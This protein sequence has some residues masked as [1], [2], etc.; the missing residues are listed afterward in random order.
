[1]SRHIFLSYRRL[2]SEGYAG[3]LFDRLSAHFG[4]R[5]LFMDVVAIDAGVDFAQELEEAVQ[6]CDVLLALI[7]PQWLTV[8][9]AQGKPRLEDPGD[10]VRLEIATALARDIRVIPVL[11]QGTSMPGA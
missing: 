3:R 2:D 10:Y 11:L 5:N 1:M 7:G 4:K 9:D 6:K 8:K